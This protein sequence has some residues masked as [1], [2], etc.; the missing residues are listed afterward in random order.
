[1]KDTITLLTEELKD[2]KGNQ[3]DLDKGAIPE[4]L[5]L[6]FQLDTVMRV[7]VHA[8]DLLYSIQQRQRILDN[9]KP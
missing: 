6:E 5:Y 4:P 2:I 3:K 1:M 8:K 9:K 7:L